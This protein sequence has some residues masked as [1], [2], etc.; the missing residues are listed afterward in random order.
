[1]P[2]KKKTAARPDSSAARQPIKVSATWRDLLGSLPGYDPFAQ[3]EGCWF[4]AEAAQL[5]I[6]FIEQCIR[7]VEGDL[8]GKPFLLEPW[9]KAIVAN[10]FGWVRKDEL[11]RTVR[12]YREVFIMVARK[13]GKTPLIAAIAL[14]VLFC[15]GEIGQQGYIAAGDREQAGMLFR[16]AKGMVEQ[17]PELASRCHIF[18]GRAEAGQ[19]RSIVRES[20]NSF[21]RVISADAKTKHGGNTSVAIVDE[22]HVQPNRDLIDVLETSMA[23]ANRKN[24]LFIN[25]TTAGHDRQSICYEKYTKACRVRDNGGDKEKPGYDPTFLPVIYETKAEEDWRDEK[26]WARANPNLGVSVSLDYLRSKCQQAQEFPDFENT[27]RQLHLNQW[28]EQAT[29]WLSMAAWDACGAVPVDAEALRGRPCWGGLDLASTRDLTAFVLVFPEDDG[30]YTLLPRFW[31]PEDTV[32]QRVKADGVRYDTWVRLGLLAQTPGDW[33]DYGVVERD[34]LQ[35]CERYDVQEIAFDPK[36]ASMLAQRLMD[37]GL[38][39][40]KFVQ[41]FSNYNE[42]VKL[43]EQLVG[44]GKLYHGNHAVLNWNAANV[45]LDRNIAGLRL[46]S[47]VKSGDKIDGIVAALMALAR[48]MIRAEPGSVYDSRGI[49][50]VGD[51]PD[52]A[53]A[54]APVPAPTA[55]ESAEPQAGSAT[56]APAPPPVQWGGDWAD[57]DD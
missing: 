17:E 53:A 37:A 6:D 26:V 28:T 7:H 25:I 34:I 50:T 55:G 12:R 5:A 11:G 22:T 40:V 18:G 47:K 57:E 2:R 49:A 54:P 39:L 4:D 31:V 21:L 15:S 46:P 41:S 36:E 42:P 45:A 29:R 38:T 35:W 10:L 8:A 19:S 14:C 23:S 48:V 3:A 30:G 32:R 51:E 20:E 27:F 44:E 43:F 24:P 33:C 52:P 9:Q 16:Q 1:M 56:S 13:N